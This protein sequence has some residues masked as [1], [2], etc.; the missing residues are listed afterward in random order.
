MNSVARW[1][2]SLAIP[3]LAILPASAV[4]QIQG[5]DS[6]V[7]RSGARALSTS[8]RPVIFSFVLR[9]AGEETLDPFGTSGRRE[10]LQLMMGESPQRGQFRRA[11]L[12]RIGKD[13]WAVE[14]WYEIR[15]NVIQLYHRDP[16]GS[17]T[18]RVEV[19]RYLEETICFQDPENGLAL[20]FQYLEPTTSAD[21]A[22]TPADSFPGDPGAADDPDLGSDDGAA[23][24]GDPDP[25]D[26]AS[27]SSP[28]P[29]CGRSLAREPQP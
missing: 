10:V 29:P 13:D 15:G 9:F 20:A 28:L 3:P 27:E 12:D 25:E 11:R 22:L 5:S 18:G 4:A 7:D 16:N 19:G 24:Q 14:G 17:A 23:A 6:P 1:L 26:E 21:L 2:V 8:H